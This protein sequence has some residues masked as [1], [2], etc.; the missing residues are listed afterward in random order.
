MWRNIQ[1]VGLPLLY[2]L[3]L[4]LNINQAFF[5]NHGVSR[6]ENLKVIF[7]NGTT[8]MI[9]LDVLVQPKRFWLQKY[10]TYGWACSGRRLQKNLIDNLC[11]CVCG[12]GGGLLLS[13]TRWVDPMTCLREGRTTY[14]H[15][16]L[17][18][19]KMKK[20]KIIFAPFHQCCQL[21]LQPPHSLLSDELSLSS[22]S[23]YRGLIAAA[24]RDFLWA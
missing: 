16:K 17:L 4:E 11:M 8:H 5:A 7:Q 24:A 1:C 22:F 21:F 2:L 15:K 14:R 13:K 20:K 6:T 10:F 12:G 23:L 3:M 9:L 19:R 18:D